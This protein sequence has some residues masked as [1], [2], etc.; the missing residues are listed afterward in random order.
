MNKVDKA[1]KKKLISQIVIT[2]VKV[3]IVRKEN[4]SAHKIH[5]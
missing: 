4:A 5:S 3:T 1:P 2:T